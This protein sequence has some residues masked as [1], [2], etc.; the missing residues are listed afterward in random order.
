MMYAIVMNVVSPARISVRAVVPFS[1][2]LKSCSMLFSLLYLP[3]IIKNFRRQKNFCKPIIA[4]L[5]AIASK[6]R[7][8]RMILVD[9][10]ELTKPIFNVY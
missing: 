7:A 3:Q 10:R 6:N 8:C 4:D 2:S 1:L 9:A 5:R